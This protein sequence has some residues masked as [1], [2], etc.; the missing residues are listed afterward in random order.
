MNTVHQLRDRKRIEDEAARWVARLDAEDVT[1]QTRAEFE[2]W[3]EADPAHRRAYQAFDVT[4]LRLDELETARREEK[5][6][7]VRRG[8]TSRRRVAIA[9]AALAASVLVAV[10]GGLAVMRHMD[11]GGARTYATAVGQNRSVT[12]DDGSVMEL[13]TNTIVDVDYAD[14]RRS[15]LLRK[16]EA[17]FTVAKDPRRPFVV[18]AGDTDV[19]AVGTAFNV[20]FERDVEVEV[21]VTEGVVDVARRGQDGAIPIEV[22]QAED[23]APSTLAH[24][25]VR[26]KAGQAL[27]LASHGMRLETLPEPVI[28]KDLAWR[29]GQLIFEGEPL[30]KVLEELSRYSETRFII[31][32]DSIRDK[33][34]GGYFRTDDIESLLVVL[35]DVLSIRVERAGPR[36]VYLAEAR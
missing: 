14:E 16:G 25:A 2:R 5:A 6:D 8:M 10:F 1:E 7:V 35:E 34:V 33:R 27:V 24:H 22:G 18:T 23:L 36:V 12:L 30:E 11:G 21:V 3:I 20:F 4:W 15:I 26:L 17:Y 32:D 13:N 29:D 9:G 28:D 31:R 19:R